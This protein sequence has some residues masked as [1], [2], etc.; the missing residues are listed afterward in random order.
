M[1]LRV[2]ADESARLAFEAVTSPRNQF[3]AQGAATTEVKFAVALAE[4]TAEDHVQ[5]AGG[6]DREVVMR[7][8][9][10]DYP[11]SVEMQWTELSTPAGLS[12]YWVRVL[13]TDGATA[14]SSPIFV[15]R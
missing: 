10:T 12:A 15:R 9:G 5:T 6:V 8:I 11:R 2:D 3:G 13:Q 1:I 4:L 7:R 14:W